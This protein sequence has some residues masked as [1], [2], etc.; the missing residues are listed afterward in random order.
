M[1]SASGVSNTDKAPQSTGFWVVAVLGWLL[2][3]G[4]LVLMFFGG[5][6]SYWKF[7]KNTA[8]NEQKILEYGGAYWFRAEGR[9][10]KL[11]VLTDKNCGN[12]CDVSREVQGLKNN[13]SPLFY[14]QEVDV[15]SP[16]GKSLA[17]KFSVDRLPQFILGE[18][19]ESLVL[20]TGEKFLEAAKDVYTQQGSDYLLQADKIGLS[21]RIFLQWPKFGELD[22]E[23]GLRNKK[24]KLTIIEFTDFQCPYCQRLNNNIKASVEKLVD[25]GKINY[26]IKDFPLHFHPNARWGHLA[27][28]KVQQEV[29]DEAYF[30]FVEKTF[31]QQKV[32]GSLPEEEVKKYF[33][34]L[35]QEFNVVITDTDWEDGA[36]NQELYGDLDEGRKYGV[37]GTPALF[38][39]KKLM[40]GAIGA[41]QFEAAVEEALQDL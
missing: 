5:N 18:G 36:L 1:K 28:N 25:Q 15:K 23:P 17:K 12:H 10:V 40:P 37:S 21:P 30:D 13:V 8:D 3:L 9:P 34:T 41:A 22:Q 24:A 4:A 38:I 35:A 16:E 7:T 2:F 33:V 39:G 27:A 26:V 31:N 19:V 11:K 14:T 29:G 6:M 20:P 32:W